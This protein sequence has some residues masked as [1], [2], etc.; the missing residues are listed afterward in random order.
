MYQTQEKIADVLNQQ[1]FGVSAGILGGQI[2][3]E[4]LLAKAKRG[5]QLSQSEINKIK[6]WNKSAIRIGSGPYVSACDYYQGIMN[7]V[8]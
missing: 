7:G 2:D 3:I 1:K 8:Y 4:Q 5:V 6:G